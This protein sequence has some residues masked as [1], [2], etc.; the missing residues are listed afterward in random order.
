MNNITVNYAGL[1][2]KNPI[3]IGANNMVFDLDNIKRCEDQ[4]AAAVVYKSLFEEQIG[5]EGIEM[6]EE[7][8]EYDER[9][10]EMIT[11]HPHIEHGGPEEHLY[12]LRKAKQSVDIPIIA[13]LNAINKETWV[14]YARE[15]EKTGVDALELNF[16]A[17]PR[18]MEISGNTIEEEQI[19]IMQA[20]VEA[21]SIPVSVKLSPFYTNPLHVISQM[22]KT[23]IKGFVL[24]NRLFQPD[25]NPDKQQHT[26]PFNLSNQ[27][28]N[29]LPLRFAGLLHGNIS[30]DICSNTGI[31][32]G[33]DVIKMILAGATCV[34]VVSTIY[35]NKFGQ[36]SRMISEINQW[37]R[38]NN[39][40]S[41]EDFRGK[42]SHKELKD[43]FIYKRAQ[44]VDMLMKKAEEIMR[45]YP[46]A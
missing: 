21:V 1:T 5:L 32:S 12:N 38:S 34:Q 27:S 6:Q 29:R 31:C 8:T 17:V 10:P 18:N 36:I 25:I 46:L 39:Y 3:I 35:K 22:D 20:V 30:G 13:S 28:D 9:N 14:N 4:G 40:E 16:Y 37:M 42:L 43:P 23:G 11:T 24:F 19:D 44:Y 33:K 7:L 15:I 26:A 41:L 45:S 2:L